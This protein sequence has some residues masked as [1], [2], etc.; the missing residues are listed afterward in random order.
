[1]EIAMSV[2]GDKLVYDYLSRVADLARGE[3][4]PD[5]RIRLVARLREE[6]DGALGPTPSTGAVRRV[7]GRLGEPEAVVRREATG[8]GGAGAA[9][10]FDPAPLRPQPVDNGGGGGGGEQPSPRRRPGG[11]G[12]ALRLPRQSSGPRER[13]ADDAG[14]APAEPADAP[15]L[16]A[17]AGEPSAGPSP[18]LPFGEAGPEPGG[19]A[20]WDSVTW[21]EALKAGKLGPIV[22]Q[23]ELDPTQPGEARL[24]PTSMPGVVGGLIVP[25]ANPVKDDVPEKPGDQGT[26]AGKDAADQA[27]D[28][29]PAGRRPGPGR[30]LAR[31]VFG[32]GRRGGGASGEAAGPRRLFLTEWLAVG[33]LVA[34]AVWPAVVLSFGG[35]VLAYLS[36]SLR[37]WEARA[38]SIGVPLLTV[39]GAA[40]LYWARTTGRLGEVYTEAQ[41]DA[42]VQAAMSTVPR[43]AAVLS[44]IFLLWRITRG[45]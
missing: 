18:S 32:A 34:G 41:A 5:R 11:L 16:P 2:E 39:G 17:Q 22:P 33:L 28:G 24:L 20:R 31:A 4:P 6:I 21:A 14:A 30:R 10:G 23:T 45:R 29:A 25:A 12:G 27:K 9:E 44:A 26:P 43:V 37:V 19:G 42:Y 1:M 35:W 8:G 36:T 15:R 3:L 38:A 40:A 7:L 13:G